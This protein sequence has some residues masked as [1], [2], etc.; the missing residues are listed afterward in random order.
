MSF[1]TLIGFLAGIGLFIGAIMTATDNYLSFVSL[2]SIVMVLGGTLAAGFIG[3]QARY[4]MLALKDVG[5]LFVKGKVD[6]KMLTSRPARSSA[7]AIWSRNRVC[8]RW[9]ARSRAPRSRTTS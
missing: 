1:A 2:P 9:S 3:Y 7:G 8:W 4:V 6:R 5:G